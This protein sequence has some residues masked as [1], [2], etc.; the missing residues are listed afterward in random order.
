MNERDSWES[1]ARFPR[2]RLDSLRVFWGRAQPRSGPVSG[3]SV[4][5]SA[6]ELRREA[7]R[8]G[9]W[10]DRLALAARV[11]EASILGVL[12]S[13]IYPFGTVSR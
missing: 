2:K 8:D 1:V 5:A 3:S 9:R 4:T 12:P 7:C 6:A 10:R 11:R 13:T